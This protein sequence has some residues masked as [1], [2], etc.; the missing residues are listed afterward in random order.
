MITDAEAQMWSDVDA[1]HSARVQTLT[2]VM[3]SLKFSEAWLQEAKAAEFALLEAVRRAERARDQ[4][5]RTT[6]TLEHA[7]RL[8]SRGRT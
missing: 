6:E 7:V 5:A 4:L 1:K 8:H 3:L 2:A